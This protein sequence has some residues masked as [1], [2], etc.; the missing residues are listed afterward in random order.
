MKNLLRWAGPSLALILFSFALWTLHKELRAFHYQEI[1]AE[2]RGYRHGRIALA[3][4]LT[5]LSYL[6][7]TGYDAMGLRFAQKT[8]PFRI[9]AFASFISY[10]FSN[11][12]GFSAVTGGLVRYRIYSSFGVS[13]FDIA[14]IAVFCAVTFWT[15][16]LLVG[17]TVFL[18]DPLP[19]PAVLH[20][21]FQTT[22]PLG[23]LSMS[24]AAGYLIACIAIR[25]PLVWKEWRFDLPSPRYG[26]SQLVLGAMDWTAAAAVLFVLLPQGT[27]PF[28]HLVGIFI[29]AQVVGLVSSVPGGLGVFETVAMLMLKPYVPAPTA[30]GALLFF[31]A[32]YYLVPLMAAVLL[33]AGHELYRRQAALRKGV[34][35]IGRWTGPIAPWA[36]SL[37]AF[38]GGIVLL[39]SGATPGVPSRLQWLDRVFPLTLLE[40][41]HFLGSLAG[42]ALLLLARGLQQRLDGAW[43]L[44]AGLL[45]IGMVSSLIKGGDYE[46]A[47]ILGCMLAALLPSR[48]YFYRKTQLSSQTFSWSW[49]VAILVVLLST[50]WLGM[51]SYKHLEYSHEMWWHFSLYGNASRFLRANVGAVGL[52]LLISLRILLRPAHIIPGLPEPGEVEEAFAI[53]KS[54]PKT[55]GFLS[56][57]GDKHLLFSSDRKAF[58][59]YGVEGRTWVSMGDPVGDREAWVELAWQFKEDCDRSAA[60]PVFYQVGPENIPLYLDL[61]LSLLKLGE[62]ARVPLEGFSL[63]GKSRKGLRYAYNHGIKEGCAFEV[64][65]A[66]EVG[67]LLPALKA[68]SDEWLATKRTREKGFSLGR[69]DEEYLLRY[70][71][72]VVRKEGKIV[73][74]A[75]VWEGG[76]KEELS[77][78]LMR[79]TS[80]A[81]ELIM[82][83]LLVNLFLKGAAEGY[84]YFGLGM[85]PLAGFEKRSLNPAWHKLAGTLFRHGEHFYNFKGLRSFKEKFHP[86]WQPRYLAAPG[87][88]ALPRILTNLASLISGGF[89]GVVSK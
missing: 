33:F 10:V 22:F 32:L 20:A 8:L 69:F 19:L 25:K 12:M 78:D 82:E 28:P 9:T 81:P 36:F 5:V 60:W 59:M 68:V 30:L 79:H 48:P 62:D 16:L 49:S 34:V 45:S 67:A 29:I 13:A 39:V 63:E 55:Y 66:S 56:T 53:A 58:I 4:G 72:A 14:K 44:T 18:L 54:Q 71:M 86:E 2:I 21:H 77:I 3:L 47:V 74:F 70:P 89:K 88:F 23:L 73:A 75:N 41:S 40:L 51:F 17:G 42:A 87:G 80:A 6:V 37:S 57:L 65:P 27:I 52:V 26:I 7:L 11:N 61:G 35:L 43:M 85:A 38:L 24:G 76:C 15:G 46:E 1:L 50:T 84:R 64:V 83:Y 31:R